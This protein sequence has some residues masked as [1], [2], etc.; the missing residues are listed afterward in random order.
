MYFVLETYS[1]VGY[2]DLTLVKHFRIFGAMASVSGILMFGAITAF[3]VGF[4]TRTLDAKK[5]DLKG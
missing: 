4:F 5:S 2:D 3:L 1:T